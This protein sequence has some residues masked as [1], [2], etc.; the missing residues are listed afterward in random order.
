MK[1]A[2]VGSGHVG[3]ALAQALRKADHRVLMGARMPL[4][5]KA[6]ALAPIVGED[7]IVRVAEAVQRSEVVILATPPE[8]VIEIIQEFGDLG[9][10]IIIDTTNS[11]RTRPEPYR[12]AFH[13]IKALAM[14]DR[15][16]KCFNTTGYENLL[17]P[18]YPEHPIDMFAAGSDQPS[19]Q[20]AMQLATDIGFGKC[21][22]FG[23]D[24][25]VELLEQFALSWINLA[26][27]QGHGRNHGFR[28]VKR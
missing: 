25:K 16:A 6:R 10:R 14:T 19:K 13:A 5:A 23:G 9:S 1:I 12:T 22:D 8:A 7:S 28:L 26:I 18:A 24:D 21:Y 15:V 17:N 4:S 3:G 27:M 20:V 2:I 11:V